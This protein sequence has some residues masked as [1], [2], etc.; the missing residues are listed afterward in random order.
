MDDKRTIIWFSAFVIVVMLIGVA[1][2]ILLDRFLLR[3]PPDRLGRGG[4]QGPGMAQRQ[5]PGG[6]RQGPMGQ[7]AG[8]GG[9]LRPGGLN[10]R[11]ALELE[12]TAAQKEQVGAILG[13]RRARLD[14]IRGE[15]QGRMQKEQAELRAEI[16]GVLTEKQQKRFDQVMTNAPGLGGVGPGQRGMRR[17]GGQD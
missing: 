3:P 13:R 11:L 6:M 5:G 4:G 12:L 14:E 9:G 17:G 1:S 7:G 16:R 10:E 15:M 8:P 2:G